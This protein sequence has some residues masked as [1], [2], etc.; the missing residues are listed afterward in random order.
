MRVYYD[1]AGQ[2]HLS[3]GM[4]HSSSASCHGPLACGE[5]PV[6]LRIAVKGIGGPAISPDLTCRSQLTCKAIPTGVRDN[7]AYLLR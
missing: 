4:L 7:V 3:A 5:G 1:K 2:A 6:V